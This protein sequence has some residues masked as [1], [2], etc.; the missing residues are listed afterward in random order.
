MVVGQILRYMGYV[1]DVIAEEGQIVKGAII[2]LEDD[3]RI[4]HA[5]KMVPTIEFYRYRI[6]FELAKS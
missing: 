2:A 6:H 5:L 4:R 1:S 3:Q